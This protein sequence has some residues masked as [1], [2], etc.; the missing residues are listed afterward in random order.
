MA[1]DG[2]K[3]VFLPFQRGSRINSLP[4]SL[5]LLWHR[6]LCLLAD[7]PPP[8]SAAGVDSLPDA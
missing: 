7:T 2:V 5:R 1:C 4:A 8:L 6:Y 3:S